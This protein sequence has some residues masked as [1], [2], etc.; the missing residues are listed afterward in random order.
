MPKLLTA[1]K[2]G[3][4]VVNSLGAGKLVRIRKKKVRVKRSKRRCM[5]WFRFVTL[6]TFFKV[7]TRD[8]DL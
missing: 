8:P 4:L 6:S 3:K 7:Q 1:P 2:W 5:A